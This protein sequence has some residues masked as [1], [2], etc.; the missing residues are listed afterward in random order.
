MNAN[1]HHRIVYYGPPGYRSDLA[2]DLAPDD[3]DVGVVDPRIPWEG[4]RDLLSE[5]ETLILGGQA[6]SLEE[7]EQLPR[8]R[9]LQL[10]SAGYD[11]ID[12]S[13]IR[14]RGVFV[15]NNS[16]R[17][18]RS[19]A[20]HAVGLMLMVLHRMRPGVDGVQAG[21]WK[22]RVDA[23]PMHEL[24]EVVIGIVGLGNI[25]SLVA[26]MVSGFEPEEILYHDIARIPAGREDALGVRR[27][28]FEDLLGR[29]D[30]VTAHVPLYSGTRGMFNAQ[31]FSLMKPS[32]IFINT[33]RG[34]VHDEA[35]LIEALRAGGIAGAGLDV[36]E[37]EPTAMDNPL[38]SMGNVVVT[39]HQAGSSD[40]RVRRALVFSFENARRV[41]NGEEPLDQFEVLV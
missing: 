4:Q 28:S 30:I 35:D 23:A 27:T 17:I 1:K 26:R 24:G 21:E 39:P 41:M 29:S 15:A 5:T 3:L 14:E 7:I 2:R 36:L 11:K 10:M 19:V 8:L 20:E 16:P 12:V 18:A 22:A 34:P 37:Q 33:C 6:L 25:G 40:E 9:L 31:A 32:A 38:L 13:G